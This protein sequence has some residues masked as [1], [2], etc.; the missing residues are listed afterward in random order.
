MRQVS[1]ESPAI[2]DFIETLVEQS[3]VTSAEL[4]AFLKYSAM[5][6]CNLGN[7]YGEGD[8]KFVPDLTAEALRK[9][10][11]ISPKTK[12]SLEKIID[13]LI[14]VPPFSLGYPGKNTQ[15]FYYLGDELVSQDEVNRVSEVMNKRSIGPENTRIRKVVQGRKTILQ[16]LQASAELGPASNQS[17]ELAEGILLVRGDHSDELAQVCSALKKAREHAGNSKQTA[18][19]T[20]FIECCRTGSLQAFQ[21]SQKAWV[22]DISARVENIIGF[23][24]PYRDPA[25]IRSEWKAMIGI[26]DPD[27]TSRLKHFVDSSVNGG[28]GPFEKS[29]F[30]A[31]DFTSVHALAV[32]GSIVFEAANLPNYEYIRE[33]Y[34]FKNIV[35]ANRLSVNNNP[36]LPCY[37]VDPSELED[38]KA[39]THVV[40][41]I[42]TAIHELIRHGSGKLLSEIKPGTY[43][44]DKQNPPTNPLSGEAVTSHYLPSQTW[45]SVFGKL[46]GTVEE[47]R[48]ILMSEYLMDNKELLGIF[49][50]TNTGDI[51]ANNLLYCTYMNIG[52]DGLQALEH[53][54][55]KDQSWGQVH[56]QAHFSILKHLL[57]DGDGV[58]DIAHDTTNRTLTVHVDRSKILSHGKPTLAQYL[59]RLHIWRCT[60]DVSSCRK[61]YEPMCAVDGVWKFVQPNTVI[62]GDNVDVKVYEASNEEIIRSWVERDI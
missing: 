5:L 34:G 49:G 1:S 26:A 6:L 45:T 23:I 56:H 48:A 38:F 42:T 31:P 3:N 25:G 46:A 22:T 21:E 37:W 52:V 58:I 62:R 8:Q 4:A 15:S 43:D 28:K 9:I 20:H 59:C 12:A 19:L 44:F 54:N 18:F 29:L 40:R 35:L 16:L 41:F 17:D 13:R 24:E 36:N 11:A 53:Y 32:C 39:S 55:S 33:T 7:F 14:A 57:Q 50:Y 51:T 10:A 27:E 2:F 30:E 60:A 47:C 61:F